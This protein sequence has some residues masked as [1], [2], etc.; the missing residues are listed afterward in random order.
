MVL[1]HFYESKLSISAQ[2]QQARVT[3]SNKLCLPVAS[4]QSMWIPTVA[5]QNMLPP[6]SSLNRQDGTDIGLQAPLI[7]QLRLVLAFCRVVFK[8][9]DAHRRKRLTFPMPRMCP[10]SADRAL[11]NDKQTMLRILRRLFL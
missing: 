11:G 6:C 8:N 3:E 4:L 1:V 5:I 9:G 7:A 10:V 2:R